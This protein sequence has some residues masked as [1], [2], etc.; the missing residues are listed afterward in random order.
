MYLHEHIPAFY[1][2]ELSALINFALPYRP[3]ELLMSDTDSESSDDGLDE[4][5]EEEEET[6]ESQTTIEDPNGY[7]GNTS[8]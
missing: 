2:D 5:E 3:S 7:E 6:E 1:F 4:E 8:H